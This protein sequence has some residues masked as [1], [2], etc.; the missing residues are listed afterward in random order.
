[1]LRSKCY[2][3]I[4]THRYNIHY[5]TIFSGTSTNNVTTT[6]RR[7]AAGRAGPGARRRRAAGAPGAVRH[8]GRHT[9]AAH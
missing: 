2:L 6:H 7:A 1:M 5:V 4:Y 9:V 3:V 8:R